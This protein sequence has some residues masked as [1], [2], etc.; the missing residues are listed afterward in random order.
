MIEL[1]CFQ[2]D[3]ER[4]IRLSV[5]K[6]RLRLRWNVGGGE[7]VIE[8]PEVLQPT[9]DDADH[10]T[11]RLNIERCSPTLLSII[12]LASPNPEPLI[13]TMTWKKT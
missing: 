9:L 3:S 12:F 13:N 8:H 7:G 5:E 6:G 1:P 2:E 11:Y 4:Y 10:T